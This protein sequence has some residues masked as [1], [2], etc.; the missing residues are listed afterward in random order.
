MPEWVM[1]QFII[2]LLNKHRR[3]PQ[4]YLYECASSF[5]NGLSHDGGC[6]CMNLSYLS[7]INE[8]VLVI[9]FFVRERM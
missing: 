1:H 7:I 6:L 8:F 9:S 2:F 5:Q 4:K 3:G